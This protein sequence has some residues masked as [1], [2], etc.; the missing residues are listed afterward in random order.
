MVLTMAVQNVSFHTSLSN[1]SNL[2]SPAPPPPL[3]ARRGRTQTGQSAR[4][5]TLRLAGG[6]QRRKAFQLTVGCV[7]WMVWPGAI[8][9]AWL[10][11]PRNDITGGRWRKTTQE[12][13]VSTTGCLCECACVDCIMRCSSNRGVVFCF[14]HTSLLVWYFNDGSSIFII[15]AKGIISIAGP[16]FAWCM[17]LKNTAT[18]F[19]PSSTPSPSAWHFRK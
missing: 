10:V 18:I 12:V 15:N 5:H 11:I 4:G 17:V 19:P 8:H 3:A 1:P 16:F 13:F 6:T 9:S 7:C 14:P 2:A